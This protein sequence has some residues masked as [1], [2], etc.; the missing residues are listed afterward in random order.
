LTSD[1]LNEH[2]RMALAI[3]LR[4]LEMALRRVLADL[5]NEEQGVLYRRKITLPGDKRTQVQESVEAALERIT[6][7]AGDFAL[8]VQVYDNTASLRGSLAILRSDLYDARAEKLRRYGAV[9]P[10][11]EAALDPY[12][13]DLIEL[14][15][16]ISQTA[17]S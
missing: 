16:A 12:L 1:L 14:L 15:Q 11:L 10:R 17:Q 4:Q 6:Q 13:W 3:V 2:Q 8:P 7:L 5:V 9:D